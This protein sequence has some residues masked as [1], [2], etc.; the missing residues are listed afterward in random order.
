M[1]KIHAG[2]YDAQCAGI[3]FKIFKW[4]TSYYIKAWVAGPDL[5]YQELKWV[6]TLKRAKE[7]IQR[8]A[9]QDDVQGRWLYNYG[10]DQHNEAK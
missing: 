7:E 9:N 8:F 5:F 3:S 6:P 10:I 4:D 1:K 2:R